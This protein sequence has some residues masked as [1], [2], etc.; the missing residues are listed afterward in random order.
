MSYLIASVRS[1]LDG[2]ISDETNNMMNTWSGLIVTKPTVES[3]I[4]DPANKWDQLLWNWYGID[5]L[6]NANSAIQ[7]SLEMVIVRV[8]N[9]FVRWILKTELQFTECLAHV[10]KWLKKTL[11]K[12]KKNTKSQ[13]YVQHKLTEPKAE[14]ISSNYSTVVRQNRGQSAALIAEGVN[15]LL[16]SVVFTQTVL[17][18]PG[19][20][21][22]KTSSSSKP[23]PP[24][25]TN[26]YPH[27][28]DKVK[29]VFNIYAQWIVAPS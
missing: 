14:Y 17:K 25:L 7:L 29:E 10:S 6:R 11:C 13:I 21:G 15:I 1:V 16:M 4:L 22:D 26:Y 3:T 23:P 18:I 12:I 9:R 19:V 28:I 2:Q 24:N 8:F 27:E 5:L 20:D